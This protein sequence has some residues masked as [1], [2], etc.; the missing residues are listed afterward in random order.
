MVR[1]RKYRKYHI[2]D[3]GKYVMNDEKTKVLVFNFFTLNGSRKI[4][5]SINFQSTKS[6]NL[7]FKKVR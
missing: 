6:L 4:E 5:Y 1:N 2:F 3:Y 7:K